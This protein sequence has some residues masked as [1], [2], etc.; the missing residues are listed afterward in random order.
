[1]RIGVR[2]DQVVVR[3]AA[4]AAVRAD[5]TGVAAVVRVAVQAATGAVGCSNAGGILTEL[6]R[7]TVAVAPVAALGGP[8]VA[9]V[10]EA[11]VVDC[12]ITIA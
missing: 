11:A 3:A 5:R 9:P 10:A 1:M 4:P 12:S 6:P 7:P 8:A 2:G